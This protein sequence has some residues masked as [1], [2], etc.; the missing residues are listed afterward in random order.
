MGGIAGMLS[1]T[2]ERVDPAKVERMLERLAHRGPDDRGWRRSANG[3]LALGGCRMLAPSERGM[4]SV[5][6]V[7]EDGDVWAV[8]DGEIDNQRALSHSLR[9]DGHDLRTDAAAELVVHAYEQYGLEF[10]HHLHGG[11]AL[12]LWDDG[13]QRLLLARDRLGERPL[14]WSSGLGA[15]AFASEGRILP[16]CLEAPGRLDVERLPEYFA[17]GAVAAPH[18]LFDGIRKLGPGEALVVE[19]GNRLRPMVWWTPCSDPHRVAAIRALSADHHENNLRVLA[20]SAIA[21]RLGAMRPI[22]AVVDGDPASLAMAVTMGRLLGRRPEVLVFG[23]DSCRR[24][25]PAAAASGLRLTAV[26]PQETQVIGRLAECWRA[27]DEPLADPVLLCWWWIGRWMAGSGMP[28][29]LAASGSW[30]AMPWAA[31]ADLPPPGQRIA[32]LIAAVADL[33]GLA[34]RLGGRP[35][36]DDPLVLLTPVLRRR[37]K[38]VE[39]PLRRFRQ[40]VPAA[41]AEDGF[42]SLAYAET[43]STVADGVL[44]GLD[45]MFMA[46]SVTLRVPFLDDSLIDYLLALPGGEGSACPRP[47][48]LAARALKGLGRLSGSDCGGAVPPLGR[49]FRGDLAE[50]FREAAQ[51]GRL[52]AAGVLDRQACLALLDD[53]QIGRHDHGRRLWSLLCLSR[54]ADFNRLECPAGA[55]DDALRQVV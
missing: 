11:F 24:L 27:M 28:A 2:R 7:N 13:R 51:H 44:L 15:M 4:A 35:P 52:F 46:H 9:L 53:H 37:L 34:G 16:D 23:D 26:N 3:R 55:L 14:Y 21:D 25:A 49:W 45:R 5:P 47:E 31:G 6:S 18:T 38:S 12:A 33:L 50:L 20:E 10:L 36:V 8:I 17:C 54:W 30:M 40:S 39:R 29:A 1:L 48:A 41:I 43:R 42:A 32:R 22:S 19:R